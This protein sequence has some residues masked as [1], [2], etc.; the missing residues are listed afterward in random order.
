VR[1]REE[2]SSKVR[3]EKRRNEREKEGGRGFGGAG[4]TR[5]RGEPSRVEERSSI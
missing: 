5:L 3:E 2:R 4:P 1:S